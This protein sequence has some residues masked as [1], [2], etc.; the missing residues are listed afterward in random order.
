MSFDPRLDIR[1][2][3]ASLSFEYGPDVFGPQPEFRRLADIRSSL[4]DSN[5]EGP[6]PV[7]AI[8][9]DVGRV[10]H[11]EELQKRK[12]LF[13]VVAYSSGKLGNE[14]IRSQGHVHAISSCC[15]SSTPELIEIWSGRAVVYMQESADSDPGR[16]F[17][18]EA[19]PGE[20]I[21]IP[22]AWA[23]CVINADPS[24]AMVFGACC[25]RD[26]GFAYDA[27]RARGGLAWF[28]LWDEIKHELRW[29]PNPAY[30]VSCLG[31]KQAREYPELDIGRDTPIYEQFSE[32][33]NTFLWISDPSKAAS[34][35]QKFVP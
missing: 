27:I 21:V 5:C 15:G 17:A 34:V 32:E 28:P 10:A 8:A 24:E 20:K 9:M 11:R 25:V 33:P 14:L 19:K 18:V 16:C 29:K 7:Y 23:H 6:D 3:T 30:G 1:W 35:W 12:L 4:L 22:P 2:N 13:G 31:K 26:Y